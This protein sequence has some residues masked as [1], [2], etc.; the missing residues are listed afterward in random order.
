MGYTTSL[1]FTPL[2]KLTKD[3]DDITASLSD[4]LI[5]IRYSSYYGGGNADTIDMELD[6]RGWMIDLPNVGE[7]AATVALAM[8]YAESKIVDCGTYAMQ[9][10]SLSF[11][12][13]TMSV[14]GNSV[15]INSNLKAP[16]VTSYDGKSVADIVGAI[17]TSAG[18][19]LS[20]DPIFNGIIVPYLNQN[21]SCGHLL[22]DLEERFNG[23]AHFEDGHLSFTQRGSGLTASGASYG[24]I[25]LDPTDIAEM[26]VT[27]T[28]VASYSK[29]RTSWW[30]KVQ[31]QPVWL[32]STVKGDSSSTV[33][34]MMGRMYN[35]E[36]EAQ[37]AADAQ[38][39]IL[40]RQGV[41]GNLTLSKGD[42]SIR[43]GSKMTVT[44]TRDG[45]DSTY[46]VETATHTYT[47]DAG[48]T[49]TIQFCSE[50][51]AGADDSGS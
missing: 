1:G 13:K 14:R 29:V 33:P 46:T 9:E 18:F 27:L 16:I 47:K 17:A 6:D 39:K 10:V 26:K 20:V 4:R 25:T 41:T 49:T 8:G 40:N 12:P 5:S 51:G 37:A 45:I 28:S 42:P 36:V 38:M 35:S 30:D 50:D 23:V 24:S 15:N 19:T 22:N 43:G 2:F 31:H 3:G 32:E 11:P 48:I 21:S 34:F 7:G 44:G